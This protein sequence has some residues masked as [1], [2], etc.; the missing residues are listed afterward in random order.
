MAVN[1]QAVRTFVRQLPPTA[2]IDINR[3]VALISDTTVVL[4]KYKLYTDMEAVADDWLSSSDFYKMAEGYF[5][6]AGGSGYLYCVPVTLLDGLNKDVIGT[7][8]DLENDAS[9]V[10]AMV[11]ADETIRESAQVVD[12][13]LAAAKY[14]ASYHMIFETDSAATKTAVTTDPASVNKAVYDALTGDNKTIVGNMSFVYIEVPKDFQA[15]KICGAM[16][17]QTIG[18]RTAKFIKPLLSVPLELSGAELQF[19][20]DK[21]VNVFTGTNEKVGQ[22]FM[23]EGMSLKA[24]NF[25]DTSLGAIWIEVNLTNICYELFYTKK[26]SIDNVGFALLEN[27]TA[28]VFK[29]AQNLGIIQ[30]GDEKYTMSFSAGDILREI[31]GTYTYLESVAGHFIR[32]DVQIK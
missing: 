18:S 2:F 32:N 22:A 11:T 28:P 21:N 15:S 13:S 4:T 30:Q 17:G 31:V 5:N 24:G 14:S 29:L 6:E 27:A 26:V 16:M 1:Q 9:L 19:L 8:T 3:T 25:I 12:G 7:L 20:M 23:K 10:W